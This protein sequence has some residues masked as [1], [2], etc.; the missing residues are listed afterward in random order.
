MQQIFIKLIGLKFFQPYFLYIFKK[1]IMKNYKYIFFLFFLVTNVFSQMKKQNAILLFKDGSELNCFARISGENIRYTEKNIHDKE[2]VVDEKD[3]SGIKIYMNDNL[4]EF[5]Y[6]IEE[7]KLKPRLMHLVIKGKTKL[8][9]INDVYESNIGF[10]STD[11]LE[12]KNGNS[13]FFL[14]SKINK[15]E[16]IRIKNDFEE[17]VKNYFS[18]CKLLTDRIGEDNFRKKDIFKI[19]VFYNENCGKN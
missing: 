1:L 10:T 8:Y 12:K 19:V 5:N 6:K 11:I 17:K 16:V 3:L 9:R 2:I 13:A 7:G 4:V 15:N 18:D 14:E